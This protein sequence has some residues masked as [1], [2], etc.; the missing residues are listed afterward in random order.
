MLMRGVS[1]TLIG[2]S[3]Q[4]HRRRGTDP[5]LPLEAEDDIK[6][7]AQHSVSE[8]SFKRRLIVLWKG[9]VV[10][11]SVWGE[12]KGGVA[13]GEKTGELRD[14]DCLITNHLL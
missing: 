8:P 14:R 4:T 5:P 11:A 3:N 6:M 10:S 12:R 1:G 7:A 2:I 13:P 9:C